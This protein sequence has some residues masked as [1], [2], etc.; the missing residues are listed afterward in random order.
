MFWIGLGIG[1]VLG[2]VGTGI[3]LVVLAYWGHA[4]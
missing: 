3:V 1:F 2:S 4:E